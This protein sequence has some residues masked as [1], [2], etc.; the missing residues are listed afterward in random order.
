MFSFLLIDIVGLEICD[1]IDIDIT[2]HNLKR[3]NKKTTAPYLNISR[4]NPSRNRGI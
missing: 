1:H 3:V 4:V 2:L